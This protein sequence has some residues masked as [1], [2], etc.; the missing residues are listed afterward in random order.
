MMERRDLTDHLSQRMLEQLTQEAFGAPV[1][2]KG[3]FS[4]GL[5][6]AACVALV[7]MAVNFDTVYAAVQRLMYFLP[8]SGAVAEEEMAGDYWLPEAEFTAC[9]RQGNYVVSYLYRRGD[10]LDRKS[11]V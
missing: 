4:R 7:V 9:T 11:V 6:L 1:K 8:G 3:G 5:A 2:R 10:T